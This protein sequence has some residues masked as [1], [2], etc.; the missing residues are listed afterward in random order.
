ML[1]VKRVHQKGLLIFSSRQLSPKTTSSPSMIKRRGDPQTFRCDAIAYSQI[2]ST[3]HPLCHGRWHMDIIFKSPSLSSS[4][5]GR[6]H[7]Q[8]FFFVVIDHRQLW[9]PDDHC[10]RSEVINR[11]Y[12]LYI[13][14]KTDRHKDTIKYKYRHERCSESYERL[15]QF[16]GGRCV[17]G[18]AMDISSE[19]IL[20]PYSDNA[21]YFPRAYLCSFVYFSR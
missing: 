11:Q 18:F 9:L 15:S 10:H 21:F 17:E 14:E 6:L 4:I 13:R 19:N 16:S 7:R 8:T 5:R 3:D 1:Q 2:R 20:Y 12:W